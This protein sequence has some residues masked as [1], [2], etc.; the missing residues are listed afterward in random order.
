ML[1]NGIP[2]R[3]LRE[4]RQYEQEINDAEIEAWD[5][6]ENAWNLRELFLYNEEWFTFY[7][8]ESIVV[9]IEEE[10][11]WNLRE[12]FLYGEEWFATNILITE[13]PVK[14]IEYKD[15]F[16]LLRVVS[17]LQCVDIRIGQDIITTIDYR[18]TSKP[19]NPFRN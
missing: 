7:T 4:A 15:N 3:W 17:F 5:R 11:I 1:M 8:G 14:T 12:L 18:D 9:R 2:L 6:Q 16:T 19:Y 13:E 10:N